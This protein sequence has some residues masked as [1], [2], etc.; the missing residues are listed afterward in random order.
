[1]L[2]LISIVIQGVFADVNSNGQ[3]CHRDQVFKCNLAMASSYAG[4]WPIELSGFARQN[5]VGGGQYCSQPLGLIEPR[6]LP[7]AGSQF[8]TFS[9]F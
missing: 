9:L 8:I 4:S 6:P 5:S 7:Y 1:M 2:S 3:F